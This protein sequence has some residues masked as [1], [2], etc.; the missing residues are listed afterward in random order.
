MTIQDSRPQVGQIWTHFKGDDYHIVGISTVQDLS[1]DHHLVVD[2][3]QAQEESTGKLIEVYRVIYIKP[4]TFLGWLR[5][6]ESPKQT[7]ITVAQYQSGEFLK[8]PMVFYQKVHPTNLNENSVIWA[9]TLENFLEV[10]GSEDQCFYNRFN[11]NYPWGQTF[12]G[13]TDGN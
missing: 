5:F 12:F 6:W 8:H 3:Y 1:L 2:S 11:L 9:R 7:F 4:R 10:L 13:A